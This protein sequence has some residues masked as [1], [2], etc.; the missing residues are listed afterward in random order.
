[1]PGLWDMHFHLCWMNNNDSL[2]FPVLLK[3]GIT[4]IRDMGGDLHIMNNFK[5]RMKNKMII[6]PE[7]YG[8]GPILD[9][10]PPVQPDF[11]LPLDDNSNIENLLDSLK[12][13]GAEFFKVY[14]LIKEKQPTA[15]AAYCT[16]HNMTFEGH[17]SE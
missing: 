15:I 14:S 13:N 8:A 17:L 11:S 1:M 16:T 7:I 12:N 9:G 2:L 10:N 4:G 3:N 5:S 6:A